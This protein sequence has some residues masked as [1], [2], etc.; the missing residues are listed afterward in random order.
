MLKYWARTIGSQSALA[1]WSGESMSTGARGNRLLASLSSKDRAL[2]EPDLETVDLPLRCSLAQRNRRIEHVYFVDS[3]LASIVADGPQPI[4]VGV[5]GNEGMS[6]VGV[7]LGSDRSAQDIYMQIAGAGRRIRA[8]I[9]ANADARSPALHRV[10]MRYVNALIVQLTH[11]AQSNGK[12][13][14]ED[15]LAR[16]LL[17]AHD[18]LQ[19]DELPLTHELLSIMLGTPRPGVTVALGHLTSE[20]LIETGRGRI[21]ILK[22]RGLEA[23]CKGIYDPPD[24]DV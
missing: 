20:G 4:E 13:K 14:A 9:L 18:R 6:S 12:S 19:G 24:A 10:L 21:T 3:G 16:W 23:K 8:E 2:L 1:H 15:R 5:I 22:R 11:T 7:L 17:L